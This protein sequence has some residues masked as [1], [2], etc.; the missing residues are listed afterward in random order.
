MLDDILET[1]DCGITDASQAYN[2][3]TAFVAGLPNASERDAPSQAILVALMY[4]RY[5]RDKKNKIYKITHNNNFKAKQNEIRKAWIDLCDNRAITRLYE[6]VSTDFED[7]LTTL[8][9]AVLAGS[10]DAVS[11]EIASIRAATDAIAS[12]TQSLRTTIDDINTTTNALKAERDTAAKKSN[13]KLFTSEIHWVKSIFG[14]PG[15]R[16]IG[17]IVWSTV[18]IGVTAA[19]KYFTPGLITKAVGLLTGLINFLQS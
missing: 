19:V 5:S 2:Q 4:A 8:K 17:L 1:V 13:W 12:N 18:A 14:K 9:N 3:I 11:R 7:F 10:V 15:E 6:D 16:F